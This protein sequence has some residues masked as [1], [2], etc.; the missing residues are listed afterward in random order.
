MIMGDGKILGATKVSDRWR[1]S[2]IKDVRKV[3]EEQGHDVEIGDRILYKIED[4]Q[5]VIGPDN[6]Y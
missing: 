4:G 2:L 1:I 6:D 3:L 5:I